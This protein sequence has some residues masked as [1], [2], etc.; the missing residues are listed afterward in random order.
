M[1]PKEYVE[2]LAE[3]QKQKPIKYVGDKDYGQMT[4]L[5]G[6]YLQKLE[7]LG[8]VKGEG[9]GTYIHLQPENKVYRIGSAEPMT[10]E[11]FVE[12]TAGLK[13]PQK[14][15]GF[16]SGL[17]EFIHKYIFTLEDFA[18]YDKQMEQYEIDKCKIC[19]N[20]GIDPTDNKK[21]EEAKKKIEKTCQNSGLV[22]CKRLV[23]LFERT[24][25]ADGEVGRALMKSIPKLK[26][27]DCYDLQIHMSAPGVS[28]DR[29]T[30]IRDTD[31]HIK[32]ELSFMNVCKDYL[33]DSLK[34]KVEAKYAKAQEPF[35]A[36][37]KKM[38][39]QDLPDEEKSKLYKKWENGEF[40]KEYW[41]SKNSTNTKE[42]LSTKSSEERL[43]I[44]K[45][46][47]EN[48]HAGNQAILEEKA[49]ELGADEKTTQKILDLDDVELKD[50]KIVVDV[51]NTNGVV[52]LTEDE[53]IDDPNKEP[54]QMNGMT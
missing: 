40:E 28:L 39:S 41:E 12:H 47:M 45:K 13:P 49:K 9:E 20:A 34:E 29:N 53:V 4:L 22:D 51:E 2:K 26:M 3:E 8:M 19:E 46:G 30:F 32:P 5:A 50:N 36:L 6:S 27:M 16:F 31:M 54:L 18:E 42:S 43:E 52:D 21:L 10:Q 38:M 15:S 11:E 25:R 14:P 24:V 17:R 35:K 7:Q 44:G 23:D 33:P 37:K 48:I 1:G